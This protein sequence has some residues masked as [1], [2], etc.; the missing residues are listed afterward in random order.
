MTYASDRTDELD[1]L[2]ALRNLVGCSQSVLAE[3][4]GITQPSV[5]KIENQSD[6]YLSTLVR[7]IEGLG[8]SLKMQILI[9]DGGEL[10]YS[11]HTASKRLTKDADYDDARAL[12]VKSR[13]AK[14]S[15]I[16]RELEVGYNK[17]KRWIE[18]MEFDGVVGQPDHLG[19]RE[20]CSGEN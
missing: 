5:H 14:V 2:K 6:I 4:L 11:P 7:Y 8:L 15:H 13:N 3:R 18:R 16:Q 10:T 12:V 1:S 9:P 17:A 20:V 19:R